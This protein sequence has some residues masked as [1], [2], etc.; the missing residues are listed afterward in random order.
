M[1]FTT[2]DCNKGFY[3]KL[4]MVLKN[5]MT[6][7]IL[8]LIT[9]SSAQE[10][11]VYL[12]SADQIDHQG[13]VWRENTTVYVNLTLE[14]CRFSEHVGF[15]HRCYNGK[16][17]G[18]PIVVFQGDTL[19]MTISNTL[20]PDRGRL[21]FNEVHWP[22]HTSMHFH[23]VHASPDEDDVF[24]EVKPG[25][26]KT[27]VLN[28][29]DNHYPGL[30][31]YHPHWHGNS[32]YQI[33]SGLHGIFMVEAKDPEHFYPPF[34]RQMRQVVLVISHIKIFSFDKDDYHG[35]VEYHREMTDQVDLDLELDYA[36]Y[37]NTFVV[38]GK[39]QP[40]VQVEVNTWTWF[41]IL[42]AGHSSILPLKFNST[43]CV[44]YAIA[45]DGVF[46]EEPLQ[47]QAYYIFPGSRL[48]LAVYCEEAGESTVEFWKDPDNIWIY[49]GV[50]SADDQVIW[51]VETTEDTLS[52]SVSL[53]IDE[54]EAPGRPNYLDSLM[55]Y[56]DEELAGKYTIESVYFDYNSFFGFNDRHWTGSGN[57]T[58]FILELGKVYELT[59][60]SNLAVHPIH[61]HVNH[62]Q[63]MRDDEVAWSEF[64]THA[65][66]QHGTWR[67][68]RIAQL[69]SFCSQFSCL[70]YNLLDF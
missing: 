50:D 48:D 18:P 46:L 58:I 67:G 47:Q 64:D 12:Q 28:V 2:R 6:M 8:L 24:D 56:Q 15:N 68:M 4:N 34:L 27:F 25:H 3:Q 63:V 16:F 1:V 42:Y 52:S 10:H 7:T 39:Y 30:H 55:E 5:A 44:H 38:N 43:T 13:A 69:C 14:L 11:V 22:N 36:L 59:F 29:E 23:G 33:M 62:M 37:N 31:W 70:R 41:R 61:V 26:T 32:A 17:L 45:V 20:G 54:Y 9:W 35:L 40:V 51:M 57:S 49:S 66:H 19:V 60:T 21:F 53:T 65:L